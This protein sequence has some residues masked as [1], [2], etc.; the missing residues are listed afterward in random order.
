MKYGEWYLF[1]GNVEDA[2]NQPIIEFSD[3]AFQIVWQRQVW[4]KLFDKGR[5]LILRPDPQLKIVF[6]SGQAAVIP[7]PGSEILVS[8]SVEP[9]EESALILRRPDQQHS[10]FEYRLFR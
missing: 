6:F 7:E 1:L 9:S 8:L 5:L 10:V 3:G 4:I 2:S